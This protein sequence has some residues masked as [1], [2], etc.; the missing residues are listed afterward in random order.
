MTKTH[1][2][3]AVVEQIERRALIIHYKVI[4]AI[5]NELTT[6]QLID[7]CLETAKR[8]EKLDKEYTQKAIGG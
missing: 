4:A 2:P 5:A 3:Q 8:L 6:E 1:I 7:N